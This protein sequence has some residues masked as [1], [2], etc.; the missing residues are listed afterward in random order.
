MNKIT[1]DHLDLFERVQQGERICDRHA[2]FGTVLGHGE[3][4]LKRGTS[5]APAIQVVPGLASRAERL[6][7]SSLLR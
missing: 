7:S 3:K 2:T 1:A 5:R 4:S 6:Q